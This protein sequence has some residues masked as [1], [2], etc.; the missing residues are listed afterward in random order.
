MSNLVR[1]FAV[2]AV[3]AGLA[4]TVVGCCDKCTPSNADK[5][6]GDK[7]GDK[8]SGEKMAGDKMSGDKMGEKMSGDKM[9]GDKTG[10]DKMGN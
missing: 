9:A 4:F 1:S 7:M 10:K 3:V 2:I 8:M 5:M 6:S